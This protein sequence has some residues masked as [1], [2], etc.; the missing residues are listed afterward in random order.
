[1]ALNSQRDMPNSASQVLALKVGAHHPAPKPCLHVG[2]EDYKGS[3]AYLVSTVEPEPQVPDHF[4]SHLYTCVTVIIHSP[5]C[6]NY[7]NSHFLQGL[8]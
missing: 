7:K 3:P 6:E 8:N 4:N 5:H 1:M 2:V